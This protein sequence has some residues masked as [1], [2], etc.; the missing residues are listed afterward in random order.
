MN[1]ILIICMWCVA[2]SL[3]ITARHFVHSPPT[4]WLLLHLC[5]PLK[6]PIVF[7]FLINWIIL[8]QAFLFLFCVQT[9]NSKCKPTTNAN[10]RQSCQTLKHL[11]FVVFWQNQQ[12]SST[13]LYNFNILFPVIVSW[14]ILLPNSAANLTAVSPLSNRYSLLT[15]WTQ[16]VFTFTRELQHAYNTRTVAVTSLRVRCGERHW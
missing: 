5:L 2:A 8:L 14:F 9:I 3:D 11:N 7:V 13:K 15:Q 4:R 10:H 16:V 12:I 1:Q 6:V